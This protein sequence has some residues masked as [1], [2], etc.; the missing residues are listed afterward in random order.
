MVKGSPYLAVE[1]KQDPPGLE[2]ER[3]PFLTDL[4]IFLWQSDLFKVIGELNFCIGEQVEKK[5]RMFNLRFHVQFKIYSFPM[6]IS[7]P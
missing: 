3:V 4:I 5:Q 1:I 7:L 6:E 2:R